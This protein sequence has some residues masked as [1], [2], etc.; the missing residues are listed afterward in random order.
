MA[1]SIKRFPALENLKRGLGSGV[2]ELANEL[3]QTAPHPHIKRRVR[4]RPEDSKM[5][6]TAKVIFQSP[7]AWVEFGIKAHEIEAKGKALKL[8]DGRFVKK[9]HSPG[10]RA[11][12][13]INPTLV[14]VISRSSEIIARGVKK[15]YQ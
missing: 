3:A 15:D 9:V 14:S 1:S 13:F 5:K 12:P 7:A 2:I 10:A 4:E 11:Q 8:P 6:A